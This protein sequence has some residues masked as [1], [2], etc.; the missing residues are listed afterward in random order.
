MA[1]LRDLV[2]AIPSHAG[3]QI[4][5]IVAATLLEKLLG[6]QDEQTKLLQ[7]IQRDVRQILESV[8]KQNL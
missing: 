1:K 6:I 8:R 3:G 7:D 4:T 2:L 5:D